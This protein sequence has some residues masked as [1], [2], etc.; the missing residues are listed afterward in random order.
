[1]SER[2]PKDYWSDCGQ[3]FFTGGKGHGL[4][5]TLQTICL[6]N[7]SDIKKYLD[8]GELNDN[9]NPTQRQVLAQI[10]E[11]RKEEGIGTT[12]TRAAGMER[13]GNDGASRHKP[14]ATRPL[15]ARKRLPLRPPRTKNKSL[16]GK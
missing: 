15:E 16:S 4:T 1:M 12:A 13:A 7:E 3:I 9:F 5:D 6:G 8:T 10:I 14:K 11:Y 2:E